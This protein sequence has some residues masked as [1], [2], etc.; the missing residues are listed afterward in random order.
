MDKIVE[1][2]SY[3]I[4]KYKVKDRMILFHFLNVSD[5]YCQFFPKA[6]CEY[7]ILTYASFP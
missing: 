4:V 3:T 2:K 5:I 7:E 6:N 1:I